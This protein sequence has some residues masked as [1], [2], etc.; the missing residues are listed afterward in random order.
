[1]IQTTAVDDYRYVIAIS[2]SKLCLLLYLSRIFC[3][4]QNFQ[5]AAWI[6]DI[7]VALWTTITVIV[8]IFSCRPVT[9]SWNVNQRL[10]LTTVCNAKRDD[11]ENA[12][13]FRNVTSDMVLAFFFS[14][15][16]FHASIRRRRVERKSL[17]LP[18]RSLPPSCTSNFLF[19]QI[20]WSVG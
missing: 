3:L 17:V 1:M 7:V 10:N 16:P 5:I 13:G 15:G 19:A 11:V 18:W 6:I 14:F 2:L 20:F 8:A 9:A 4:D 12:Y